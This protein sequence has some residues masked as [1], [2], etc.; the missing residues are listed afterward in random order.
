MTSFKARVM[1][2]LAL[3]FQELGRSSSNTAKTTSSPKRPQLDRQLSLGSSLA[4]FRANTAASRREAMRDSLQGACAAAIIANVFRFDI[5]CLPPD[6]AQVILDGLI[7]AATLTRDTAGLFSGL[8]IWR[9]MLGEYPGVDDG[10]LPPFASSLLIDLDLAGCRQVT[11]KGLASL[12]GQSTLCHL[13]LDHCTITDDTAA[14]LA[15]FRKLRTLSMRHCDT[16]TFVTV[17]SI[18]GLLQLVSL[19]LEMCSALSGL[20][21]LQRLTNLEELNL[22]WCQSL[23]NDDVAALSALTNLTGLELARTTVSCCALGQLAELNQLKRL[24]LAGTIINDG[25]LVLLRPLTALQ[26]LDLGWCTNLTDACAKH[27]A[28]ADTLQELNFAYCQV[29]DSMLSQLSAMTHLQSLN[30]DS[31]NVS[32]RGLRYLGDLKSLSL[33]NLSENS[34]ILDDGITHLV[35]LSKLQALDLS[36]TGV[37]DDGIASVTCLTGLTYLNLDT[38]RVTDTGLRHL[39]TLAQLK[40]LDLFG[41]RISDVGCSY[42][43]KMKRLERLEVC[44]GSVTDRGVGRLSG[45]TNLQTLSLA[46][47]HGVGNP[48]LKH[49]ARL[50]KLR[51]LCLTHC[52]V[53]GGALK[54]LSTSR[55][56]TKLAVGQTAVNAKAAAALQASLPALQIFGVHV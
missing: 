16:I 29:G 3:A 13:V 9:L 54:C 6:L 49:I 31:C 22:G 4:A 34:M 45:L 23:G 26:S 2:F 10:W 35:G 8:V 50:P 46:Q 21:R 43:G 38:R 11:D 19:N 12:A 7:A 37:S 18:G 17:A 40:A 28:A 39:T 32:D 51:T 56:L 55:A 30:L 15:G 52:S 1:D 41:A 33:L 5:S 48:S 14:T 53:S 25:A 36:Y 27:I 42:L 24:G 47:N 44:G 20:R